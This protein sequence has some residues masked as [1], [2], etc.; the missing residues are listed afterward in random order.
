MTPT[1]ERQAYELLAR[2]QET[3]HGVITAAQLERLPDPIRR[4]LDYAGVVGRVPIRTVRLT[5]RGSMPLGEGRRWLPLT[6]EQYIT[7]NPPAFLW[8]GTLHP[9]PLVAVSATDRY[10]DGHG[11]MTIKA[12]SAIPLGTSRGPEMDQGELLRYLGEMAW[13]PTALLS[14]YVQWEAIDA[15]S[16]R[17]TI[18]LAGTTASGIFHVDELGRYTHV[19]AERYRQEHKRQVLRPWTGR[20]D[21][22]REINGLRI[23][24]RAEAAYTLESG[25][26]SYFRGEVTEVEYDTIAVRR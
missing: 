17:A 1:M 26:F 24:F 20:W 8:Y 2:G 3:G 18:A 10:A 19:T 16:A 7:T 12:L 9:L 4:Y 22:Y 23:P 25:G 21:D 13:Y 5:Q 14:D 11:T 6:A 15:S